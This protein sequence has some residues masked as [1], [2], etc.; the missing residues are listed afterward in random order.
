MKTEFNWYIKPSE[1][2]FKDIWETGI[3]TVDANVLLDLYRYNE[4]TRESLIKSIEEF[5]GR[6]WLSRQ[7]AEE[8]IRNRNSAIVSV[9]KDFS[10]AD[11]EIDTLQGNVQSS[12]SQ[13]KGNRVVAKEISESLSKTVYEAI[14]KA[15]QSIVAAIKD[16]PDFLLKDPILER[17]F[18][19]FENAIGPEFP[20]DQIDTKKQEAQKRIDDKI[21]PG[22]RDDDKDGDRKYGDYFL[23]SQILDHLSEGETPIIFV[24]S[25]RKDDWWEIYSGQTVGLRPELLLEASKKTD[26]KLIV[27]KTERFLEYAAKITGNEIDKDAV[28]EIQA[29]SAA[30]STFGVTVETIEQIVSEANDKINKGKLKVHLHRPVYKFTCSGRLNP[31]MENPPSVWVNLSE[32]PDDMP[33]FK[34]GSGTGTVFDFNAHIK[35]E[36]FGVPLPTGKYVL[37]YTAKDNIA[38]VIDKICDQT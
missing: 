8:F 15:K 1:E 38:P 36:D 34:L 4:A 35:S 31:E 10:K 24:T 16:H 6:A 5:K 21:P 33:T 2:E 18:E 27:Y 12:I 11:K 28:E 32:A 22:Y 17:I 3:L 26:N 30:R 29:V 7:A 9:K 23:W 20:T 13:L 25:E 14:D 19:L 37:E